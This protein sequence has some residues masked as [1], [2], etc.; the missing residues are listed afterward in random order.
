MHPSSSW[1]KLFL[2]GASPSSAKKKGKGSS[3]KNRAKS[4]KQE[5]EKDQTELT[6]KKNKPE[7]TEKDEQPGKI[8]QQVNM[9]APE[10]TQTCKEEAPARS[11]TTA[12]PN[13]HNEIYF[14]DDDEDMHVDFNMDIDIADDDDVRNQENKADGNSEA[15]FGG[16]DKTEEQGDTRETQKDNVSEETAD[17]MGAKH[18]EDKCPEADG[19]QSDE[20]AEQDDWMDAD[21]GGS[22]PV[23]T[24]KI[25]ENIF[26]HLCSGLCT[27]ENLQT[28]VR[29]SRLTLSEIQSE[30]DQNSRVAEEDHKPTST[31]TEETNKQSTAKNIMAAHEC[32]V[33]QAS[34]LPSD[35]VNYKNE[36][37]VDLFCSRYCDS[38]LNFLIIVKK[39]HPSSLAVE[40]DDTA[41]LIIGSDDVTCCCCSKRL[42]KA[43]KVYHLKKAKQVFCS[44]SCVT[45]KHPHV[46]FDTKKCY[47]CLQ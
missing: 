28:P 30:K 32:P 22:S 23:R 45:E 35:M 7:N 34:Q 13:K 29:V 47:N 20:D 39:Q 3:T 38:N 6:S 42:K 21:S 15:N 11:E 1:L 2:L 44:E 36:N 9:D 37:I 26:R 16:R 17:T 31:S 4:K 40:M 19:D 46:Q 24:G 14:S 41:R 8:P 5:S 25:S 18:I 12:A 33:C 43:S 10:E 27:Q